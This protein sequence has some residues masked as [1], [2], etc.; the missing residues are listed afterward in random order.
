MEAK[1]RRLRRAA[2][3]ACL[4]LM[5]LLA[6][7]AKDV[8]ETTGSI[9]GIVNDADNGEPVSGAHVSLNPGGL[10]ANTGSDGRYEL[11]GLEPGQ[12]TVQVSK[13]G[14]KTNS[15]RINVVAGQEAS[16]DMVL[17]RG[18]A[19]I[20]LSTNSLSFAEGE[21]SKTF[22]VMNVGTS[23]DVSWSIRKTDAWLTVDPSQG[24]TG[25]GK[26]SAVVVTID[27]SQITE[28]VSTNLLVE[29]DGESMSVA[30]SVKADEAEEP[31]GEEP[32]EDPGEDPGDD[33]S[34]D[35]E[36]EG[37]SC[38]SVA[39]WDS[40]VDVEFLSCTR[41][42]GTVELRF[43]VTN[44]REDW[45]VWFNRDKSDAF[46]NLGNTYRGYYTK[47][48]VGD[49]DSFVT[50]GNA[51][52]FLQDVTYQCRVVIPDVDDE[53]E[54]LQ[55]WDWLISSSQPWKAPEERLTLKEIRW[56]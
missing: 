3:M 43:T 24:T 55:R 32:G 37:G 6:G 48:Y 25:Q 45:Q 56:E 23:G 35:D 52:T 49:T 18:E 36:E 2:R 10:T 29:G 5:V 17:E 44:H 51:V 30:V 13:T 14:Y 11:S 28:D 53:A 9:Y 33:P 15:K 40:E 19:R 26:N 41:F 34:G 27:R 16:G 46:D 31:G 4:A 38:A 8:V 1:A 7:C 42:A 20:R 50:N 54:Y 47:I 12:Y 21:T 22:E 39:S